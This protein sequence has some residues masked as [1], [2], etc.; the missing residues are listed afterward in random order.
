[1]SPDE[2]LLVYTTAPRAQAVQLARELISLQLCACV[3]LMDVQSVYRWQGAIEQADEA[4]MLIKTARAS[5]D[6][7]RAVLAERHPYELPEIV[8]VPWTHA[9][10]PYLQWVLENSR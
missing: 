8:A 6:A 3:N 9:H 7:L 2:A 4:L 10:P 1:M 5:F